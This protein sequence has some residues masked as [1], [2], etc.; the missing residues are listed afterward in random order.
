MDYIIKHAA[1][2]K[3][4][5]Q[6][7][8]LAKKVF[9][10]NMPGITKQTRLSWSQW[11][12]AHKKLMLYA[13]VGG[14]IIAIV[15]SHLENNGNLTVGIVCVDA[16]YRK[17]G[18]AKGLMLCTEKRAKALGVH[19]LALGSVGS[20]EGFYQKL[21]FSG[22]LLIQ[23]E[24]HSIEELLSQNPGHPVV[25]TN[26]YD[27]IINQICLKLPQADRELQHLYETTFV[28]CHTQTMFWKE[29]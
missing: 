2:E 4:L 18:I 5:D 8:S 28:G 11:M 16:N 21:G 20:A 7:F 23:S 10:E 17:R 22:Q 15:F 29:I 6:A 27:G 24:K 26:V 13:E 1:T 19:L 9:G 14:K 12:N 25:F 3:E